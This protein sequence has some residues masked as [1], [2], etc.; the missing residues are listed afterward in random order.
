[1]KDHDV[2][3]VDIQVME[4]SIKVFDAS[5]LGDKDLKASVTYQVTEPRF[6]DGDILSI[7]LRCLM[8]QDVP[9]KETAPFELNVEISG[10]FHYK[11]GEDDGAI[12]YFAEHNAVYILMPYLREHVFSLTSRVGLNFH[13]P[14]ITIPT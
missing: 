10:I 13:L 6:L 11:K 4:L 5:V 8:N 3:L 12:K 9:E 14:L 1:M 7:G 2:Q